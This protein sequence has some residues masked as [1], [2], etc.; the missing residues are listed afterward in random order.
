MSSAG[1][2]LFLINMLGC[3]VFLVHLPKTTHAQSLI[4]ERYKTK[5][6]QYMNSSPDQTQQEAFDVWMPEKLIFGNED[7][8]KF[9]KIPGRKS[10]E[11]TREMS[12]VNLARVWTQKY[13]LLP[14]KDMLT[15]HPQGSDVSAKYKCDK[16]PDDVLAIKTS[17]VTKSG[18]ADAIPS[19]LTDTPPSTLEK[20]KTT[21]TELG[22]TLGTKKHGNCVLNLMDN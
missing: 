9:Q 10:I 3:F 2:F 6:V 18:Q 4:C 7:I 14:S 11:Y 17:Q 12:I 21:C 20:A 16:G 1:K 13:L 22:F 19:P 8:K 5:G 15:S